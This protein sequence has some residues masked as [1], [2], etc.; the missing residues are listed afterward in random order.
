MISDGILLVLQGILSILLLPI[1]GLNIAI[2]FIGSIPV[3]VSFLQVIAYLLPWSN[4]LPLIVLVIG[5]VI[6]KIAISLVKV[7]WQ[8]IPFM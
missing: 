1:E 6:F 2:D 5:I 3:V 8:L 4:I 7:I